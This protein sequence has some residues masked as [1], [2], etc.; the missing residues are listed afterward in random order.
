MGNLEEFF[1]QESLK[2]PPSLSTAGELRQ[3]KSDLVGCLESKSNTSLTVTTTP[4]TEFRFIDGAA[5][6]HFLLV[7]ESRTFVEYANEVFIPYIRSESGR[8][9][10]VWDVY[11]KDSLKL[12]ARENRGTRAR[13]KVSS[14]VKLP[15]G[16]WKHFGTRMNS[17]SF[18]PSTASHSTLRI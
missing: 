17:S 9:D 10:I 8:V 3:S 18:W 15:H 7:G 5:A 13:R 16:I 12:T 4:P 14:N 2:Y 6:V 1:K 11:Q